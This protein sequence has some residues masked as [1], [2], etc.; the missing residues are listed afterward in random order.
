MNGTFWE[1]IQQIVSVSEA[2]HVLEHFR[3]WGLTLEYG[4]VRVRE[5]DAV[6]GRCGMDSRRNSHT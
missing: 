2:M 5:Q 3:V 4:R 1:W 6:T